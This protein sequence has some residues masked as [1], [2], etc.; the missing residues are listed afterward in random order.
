MSIIIPLGIGRAYKY[1]PNKIEGS[2]PMLTPPEQVWAVGTAGEDTSLSLGRLAC[3]CSAS[4]HL[5][6]EMTLAGTR[7]SRARLGNGVG[8]VYC[9]RADPSSFV[10]FPRR[11]TWGL[12]K[13]PPLPG[14]H[15]QV[16]ASRGTPQS[17]CGSSRKARG[18]L[19]AW[20]EEEP[21]GPVHW[22]CR[23]PSP[24]PTP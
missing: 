12:P 7:M 22:G 23:S 10:P 14:S 17:R 16:G 24:R 20:S 11:S 4:L 5:C 9:S 15:H 18:Q 1:L 2:R 19:A 6:Q 21:Q 8:H 3:V 13:S